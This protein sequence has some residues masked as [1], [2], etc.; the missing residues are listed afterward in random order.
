MLVMLNFAGKGGV[1]DPKFSN[2]VEFSGKLV[3]FK[4]LFRLRL[5]GFYIP[6]VLN[7]V[8]FRVSDIRRPR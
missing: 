1:Y 2:M 7:C 3:D 8:D 5:L 4:D 6:N